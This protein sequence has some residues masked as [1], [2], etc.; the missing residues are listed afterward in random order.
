VYEL[1]ECSDMSQSDLRRRQISANTVV[2]LVR[3]QQENFRAG[4]SPTAGRPAARFRRYRLV[5]ELGLGVSVAGSRRV[6]P[7]IADDRPYQLLGRQA[8]T[9]A[10]AGRS[11]A[12]S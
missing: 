12:R 4:S 7:V 3:V 5:A 6:R 1:S 10:S 11:G 8:G 2:T 9:P